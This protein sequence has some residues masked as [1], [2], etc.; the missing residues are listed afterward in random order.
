MKKVALINELNLNLYIAN[1]KSTYY[2]ALQYP[3]VVSTGMNWYLTANSIAQGLSRR[4]NVSLE[5]ACGVIAALSPNNRWERNLIDADL[6]LKHFRLGDKIDSFKSATYN[7]NKEKAWQIVHGINPLEVL[8]GDKTRSFYQCIF[9]PKSDSVCID[10]HAI[11]IALGR[12]QTIAKTQGL[13]T[14][15]YE[16]LAKAYR[17]ATHEINQES[18]ES[19]VQCMQ[20]QAVTWTLYRVL[21]G[22]DNT[23][24][25]EE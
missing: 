3:T 23:H 19:R 4:H 6:M 12:Q 17:I 7:H 11:N 5:I 1:I 10:S 18:L 15:K 16:L 9:N 13:T 22:I 14:P 24:I 8:K 20:V 25:I 2:Q 21:R